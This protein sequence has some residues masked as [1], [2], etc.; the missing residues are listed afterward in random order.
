MDPIVTDDEEVTA[1]RATVVS[2]IRELDE[3]WSL[4]D[5]RFVR[6]ATHTNLIFDLVIPFECRESEEDIRCRVEQKV[7][8]INAS[9]FT[10]ITIDKE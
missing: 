9:Y 4:H 7:K 10:V 5:F 3:T 1:T 6:G 8:E 2:A